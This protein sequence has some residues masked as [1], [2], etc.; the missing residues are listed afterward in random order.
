MNKIFIYFNYYI[1]LIFILINLTIPSKFFI[2]NPLI[3]TLNLMMYIILMCMFMLNIINFSWYSYILF[4]IFIGGLMILFL[5][6]TSISPNE[7]NMTS[8]NWLMKLMLKITLILIMMSMMI[9][10]MDMYLLFINISHYEVTNNNQLNTLILNKNLILNL[11]NIM[12][13]PLNKITLFIMLYLL[14]TLI[15]IVKMIFNFNKPLRM[16]KI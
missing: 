5:Y 2:N 1:I 6:F 9:Y 12:N 3:M 8:W 13:Y 4:L 10:N 16:T 11:N 7:L 15:I 14:L